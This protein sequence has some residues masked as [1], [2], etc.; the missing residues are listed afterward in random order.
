MFSTGDVVQEIFLSVTRDLEDIR[1]REEASLLHYIATLTR[2]R[3]VDA[4]RFYEAARRDRRRDESDGQSVDRVRERGSSPEDHAIHHEQI[5]RFYRVLASFSERD[6]T[7]LRERI[8]HQRPFEELATML[9]F[10][11]GD[12]SRKAFH[13]AQ[14][15]L[16][17]RFQSGR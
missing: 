8:E 15:K 2:N 10:A 6:R 14:A 9:G 3:L 7:L 1:G 4:I 11:T 12:S 17:S 5:A 13:V 16:L